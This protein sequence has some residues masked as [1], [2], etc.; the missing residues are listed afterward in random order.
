MSSSKGFA[1]ESRTSLIRQLVKALF[2]I[3]KTTGYVKQWKGKWAENV[4][5]SPK[6]KANS[7]IIFLKFKI[8]L[9]NKITPVTSINNKV[10]LLYISSI[11][12][13]ILWVTH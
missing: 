10:K 11:M 1:K 2:T 6:E 13:A 4:R 8:Q 5:M 12:A 7:K 9:S 3:F